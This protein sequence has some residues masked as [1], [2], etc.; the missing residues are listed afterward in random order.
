[1]KH[2]CGSAA[3]VPTACPAGAGLRLDESL[4]TG[5][6]TPVEKQAVAAITLSKFPVVE[7]YKWG[8]GRQLA[9]EGSDHDPP[10]ESG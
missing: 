9:S 6:S 7:A 10:G 2:R 4:L 1:M 3:S 8:R 5:E